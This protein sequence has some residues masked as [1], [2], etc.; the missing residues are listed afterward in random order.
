M[1]SGC[2]GTIDSCNF[3]NNTAKWRGGAIFLQKYDNNTI[4]ENCTISN[5]NFT[6]NYAGSNGGAIEWTLGARYGHLINSTFI[7]NTAER[8]GGAVFWYGLYGGIN[9][10]EFYNNTVLGNYTPGSDNREEV[11]YVEEGQYC[12]GTFVVTTLL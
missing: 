10:S 2:N 7:N 11:H 1:W 12:G 8:S 9:G 6:N 3:D 4:C 5:S